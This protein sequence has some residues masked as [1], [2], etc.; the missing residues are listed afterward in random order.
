MNKILT[1]AFMSL[2]MLAGCSGNMKEDKKEAINAI[3]FFKI[4]RQN[5]TCLTDVNAE[6]D[7]L[8]QKCPIRGTGNS[9]EIV[10]AVD[11]SCSDCIAKLLKVMEIMSS[12][13]CNSTMNIVVEKRCRSSVEFYVDKY[14]KTMKYT[15]TTVNDGLIANNGY[16]GI[17]MA[18]EGKHIIESTV[19]IDAK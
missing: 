2:L 4:P 6:G 1:L 9:Q 16:N 7:Q 3:Q 14:F 11:G 15:V 19:F 17:V 10:Y 8:L 18:V 13:H 5:A 12:A